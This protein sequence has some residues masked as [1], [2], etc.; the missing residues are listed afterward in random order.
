MSED[1]PWSKAAPIVTQIAKSLHWKYRK[2]AE[3]EDIEQTIWV[4]YFEHAAELGRLLEDENASYVLRARLRA[5]GTR[6]ARREMAYRLGVD[7]DEQHDYGR[8][9]VRALLRYWLTGGPQG[10]ETSNVWAGWL[11][12]KRGIAQLDWQDS[13]LLGYAYGGEDREGLTSAERAKAWRSLR[14]LQDA[15][16][17]PVEIG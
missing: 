10:T 1:E 7:V 3:L 8:N 9:E 12:L 4:Y 17:T 14:K 2:Y 6:Y 15:M 11:D 13:A 16:N 5:A